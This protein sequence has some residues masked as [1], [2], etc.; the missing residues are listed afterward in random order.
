MSDAPTQAD[1]ERW[2]GH[3][4]VLALLTACAQPAAR[5]DRDRLSVL[6]YKLGEG[7]I[8]ADS[9]PPLNNE[10][11]G[12]QVRKEL[13]SALRRMAPPPRRE[14][15][16]SKYGPDRLALL[17]WRIRLENGTSFRTIGEHLNDRVGSQWKW[18]KEHMRRLMWDTAT[19][20]KKYVSVAAWPGIQRLLGELDGRFMA[21]KNP[22]PPDVGND[23]VEPEHPA[24]RTL[25]AI[26]DIRRGVRWKAR[27]DPK[28]LQLDIAIADWNQQAHID[29]W[30]N[31]STK[32]DARL[33][34]TGAEMIKDIDL[35][36]Y[37]DGEIRPI[38]DVTILGSDFTV[39]AEWDPAGHGLFI[40][41]FPNPLAP[42]EDI[43]F[44]YRYH[45]ADAF[46]AGDEWY[47]WYFARIHFEYRLSLT[48]DASWRIS[49]VR[50]STPDEPGFT[51]EP[52]TDGSRVAW[53][54]QFPRRTRYR[55]D[56]RQAIQPAGS[57]P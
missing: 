23:A 34:N 17:A 49:E 2:I 38:A 5:H 14:A 52:D 37:Y 13:L 55:L 43:E 50:A 9:E 32:I 54:L 46:H 22:E 35:P 19:P 12:R 26:W 48:F 20:N 27:N 16:L 1:L 41:P 3:R 30:G 47:D 29:Q 31:I 21:P 42:A 44:T 39:A 33:V 51:P 53:H 11:V 8:A 4:V 24:L 6:L 18:P 25:E 40:I 10:Q 15:A 28:V 36:V 56:W 7:A 45:H 57:Y